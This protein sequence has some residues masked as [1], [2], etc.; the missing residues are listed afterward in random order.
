LGGF[1]LGILEAFGVGLLSSAF[2]DAIAFFLLLLIL[3]FR[4]GGIIKTAVT[5]RF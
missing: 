1:L 2:K 5:E 4:P 3:Y